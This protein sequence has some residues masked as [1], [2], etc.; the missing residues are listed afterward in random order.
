MGFILDLRRKSK[1]NL[2]PNAIE[3]KERGVYSTAV[4][5]EIADESELTRAMSRHLDRDLEEDAASRS[6]VRNRNIH[7]KR[8]SADADDDDDEMYGEGPFLVT[9]ASNAS[10]ENEREF[11]PG[12]VDEDEDEESNDDLY[13]LQNEAETET[14][15]GMSMY[16]RYVEQFGFAPKQPRPL[17]SFSKTQ[18]ARCTA[19]TEEAMAHCTGKVQGR[20]EKG[21]WACEVGI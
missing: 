9:N 5:I 19:R 14:P 8:N 17:M 15:S 12:A 7:R 2:R 20:H 4:D 1:L 6:P 11:V 18:G 13:L 3:Q 16:V 10:G 21:V